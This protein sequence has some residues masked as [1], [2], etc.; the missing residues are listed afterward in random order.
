MRLA[1]LAHSTTLPLLIKRA[2]LPKHEHSISTINIH[3]SYANQ[4]AQERQT[5]A[6]LRQDAA[7]VQARLA[8]LSSLLRSAHEAENALGPDI[9]I[10]ELKAEN[11]ALREALGMPPA[12][13]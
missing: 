13:N 5:N 8:R 7:E 6:I 1:A 3:Q 4:L 12:E 10:E 11:A 9:V 2:F